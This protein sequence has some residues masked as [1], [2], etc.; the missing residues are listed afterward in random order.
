ME[1]VPLRRVARREFAWGDDWWRVAASNE[2]MPATLGTL[3]KYPYPL[4]GPYPDLPPKLLET[5]KTSYRFHLHDFMFVTVTSRFLTPGAPIK[6]TDMKD[7]T[8][9]WSLRV[10]DPDGRNTFTQ[11]ATDQ[12]N[13]GWPDLEARRARF[14]NDPYL[15]T[16][17]VD[18]DNPYQRQIDLAKLYP[19]TKPGKYR[20]QITYGDEAFDRDSGTV[21]GTAAFDVDVEP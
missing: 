4:T 1:G 6:V 12:L 8:A 20:V 19:F 13:I 16:Q 7:A 15:I 17:Q 10:R 14:A 21:L 5:D 3:F 18:K 9:F 11:R 2:S